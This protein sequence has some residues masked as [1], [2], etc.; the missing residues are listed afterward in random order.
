MA[1]PTGYTTDLLTLTFEKRAKKIEDNIFNTN[2]FINFLKRKNAIAVDGGE[3][4][5]YPVGYDVNDTVG[6]FEGYDSLD[7]TP[8]DTTTAAKYR[9]A[10][11]GGTVIINRR[12]EKQNAGESQVVKLL[13][14]KEENLVNSVGQ[15]L[16]TQF[17]TSVGTGNSSKDPF[18]LAYFI[19]ADTAGPNLGTVGNIDSSAETWWRPKSR[20][21]SNGSGT[22][23]VLTKANLDSVYLQCSRG[24]GGGPNLELTTEDLFLKYESLLFA[25]IQYEDVETVNAGFTNLKHKQSVVMHDVDVPATCWYMINT[26]YLFIARHADEW[27]KMNPFIDFPDKLAKVAIHSSMFNLVCTN[28]KKQGMLASQILA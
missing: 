25:N 23:E 12:E 10:Q 19:G 13:T 8:Q 18:G 11:Y 27:M 3:S 21:G 2:G 22:D 17:I 9:W 20:W 28:R 16:N 15:G 5:V 24:G 1:L 14:A 4:L 26:K 7:I 6:S